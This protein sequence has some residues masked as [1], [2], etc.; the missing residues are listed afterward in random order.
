MKGGIFKSRLAWVLEK[1]PDDKAKFLDALT[2]EAKKIVSGVILAG[3]WYPFSA[4]VDID[5]TL[6]NVFGAGKS[7]FL[8]DIGR[9]SAHVN[10]S[11]TYKAFDRDTNHEFFRN[12]ALLHAQFQDFGKAIY[13][14][15][16]DSSGK[17]IHT[18]YPCY[19]RVFCDSAIG[20]YEGCIT[21][22]G[23]SRAVV[24]ELECQA[25]GDKSCTF[26][27]RWFG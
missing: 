14:Q 10:I 4:L 16:G 17:M 6:M 2:P 7:E 27:L 18:E 19:S 5:R 21:S 11:G 20:Y 3:T 9:Y 8:R 26:D 12:S 15:T 25:Y 22:H 23:A 13:E 24:K 1:H